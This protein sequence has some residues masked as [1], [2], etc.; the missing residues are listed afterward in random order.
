V[1]Y[2][3]ALFWPVLAFFRPI[4]R[5]R[6]G[7]QAQRHHEIAMKSLRGMNLEQVHPS[8]ERKSSVEN[9]L[10][11]IHASSKPATFDDDCPHGILS[12]VL[13]SEP[14]TV[15]PHKLPAQAYKRLFKP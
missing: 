4:A 11:P 7:L 15:V 9:F 1:P 8:P 13:A 14:A 5:P 2:D 12:T 10:H 6:P 3:T